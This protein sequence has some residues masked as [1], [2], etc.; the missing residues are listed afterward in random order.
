[1]IVVIALSFSYMSENSVASYME[2]V[3]VCACTRVC[4]CVCG[5]VAW[6]PEQ[7]L[8]IIVSCLIWCLDPNPGPL[9]EQILFTSEPSLQPHS[10]IL[11]PLELGP[12]IIFILNLFFNRVYVCDAS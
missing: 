3:H 11:F 12:D 1:M 9:H 2:S 5:G 4:L 6:R 7:G 10:R 8:K